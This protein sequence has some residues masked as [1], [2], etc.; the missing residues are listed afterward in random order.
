MT[1]K[2]FDKSTC[3]VFSNFMLSPR[4]IKK[5][6]HV[7]CETEYLDGIELELLIYGY[8]NSALLNDIIEIV[9]SFHGIFGEHTDILGVL[10]K[11]DTFMKHSKFSKPKYVTFQL[12][13]NNTL[14]VWYSKKKNLN[15]TTIHVKDIRK[16]LIGDESNLSKRMRKN[17]DIVNASFTIYY[18]DSNI[19]GKDLTKIT[20]TGK[21]EKLAAIWANGLQILADV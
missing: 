1:D 9:I 11:G 20:I 18:G 17:S 13:K 14:L 5:T 16:I 21:N 3:S 19:N 8:I 2:Q 15:E 7:L 6:A 12:I 4:K 10:L